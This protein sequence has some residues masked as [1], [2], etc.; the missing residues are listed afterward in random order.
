MVFG[1]ANGVL[2]ALNGAAN[3]DTCSGRRTKLSLDATFRQ[4]AVAVSLASD[5]LLALGGILVLGIASLASTDRSAVIDLTL[6]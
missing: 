4:L 3:I 2:R 1:G 6:F 5:D